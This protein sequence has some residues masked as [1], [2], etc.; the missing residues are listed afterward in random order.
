MIRVSSI[1]FVSERRSRDTRDQE[2]CLRKQNAT[3]SDLNRNV[4]QV[5]I[6]I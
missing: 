1:S 6:D 4:V 2:Y 3:P 5:P